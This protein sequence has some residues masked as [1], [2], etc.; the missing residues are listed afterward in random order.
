M[1]RLYELK[2][3]LRTFLIGEN[4]AYAEL[5]ADAQWGVRLTY[6][7]DIFRHLNELNA[8]MQGKEENLLT[9]SDKLHGF[10]SKLT[11]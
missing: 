7:A 9:S 10:R 3:E 6:L 1:G 2:E 4:S 8:K 5:I 11:L